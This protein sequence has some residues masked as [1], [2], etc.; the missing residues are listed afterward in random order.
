M[1]KLIYL[2]NAAT[3]WPKPDSV[4]DYMVGFYRSCGVNPGRSG[5]DKAIEA[6]NLL[7]DLRK[8]L[9]R[10]FGGDETTPERLCFTY[11]ATDALNLIIQ[12]LLSEGDHVVTTN[13]EHNSVIRPINHLVRD[14]GVEA[15][16]VPFNGDGFV[17]PDAIKKAIRSNTK[18]VI[19]NHGS[20]VIGTIQPVKE[21]GA[22]CK[23]AGVVFAVDASQTGGMIPINMRDMN[24]DVLA[25]TGHKSLLGTTGIGGLCVREH[26]DIRPT[27][28]GGTGVRSA[29]PY[30]L[31]DYPYRMEFGTPNMVGMAS[32]WAA[33]DWIE[34]RGGIDAIYAH[35]MKLCTRLVESFKQI[36][37]VI[38][39]CCDSLNDHL[40]TLTVNIDGLEAGDVGIMLDVDFNI[41]IRTGLHCAPLVHRQLGIDKI[42]GGVRFS[43]GPFNTEDHIDA[44]I[45]AM[46]EIAERAKA[47]RAKAVQTVND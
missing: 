22:V 43:I 39:Y 15:T 5:F 33:Q 36:D 16:Y 41:A 8:R 32:L 30:H 9:T 38:A 7:E 24:V 42:H 19:V 14:G 27:R 47:M 37:G 34:E 17:E 13:V 45:E 3:S 29:Y 40:A 21:I 11:N 31:E 46:A 1:E 25:F 12:G 44:A 23:D 26:L 18:L 4:Y 35:E 6:G 2:D 20:N 28:S 10:F